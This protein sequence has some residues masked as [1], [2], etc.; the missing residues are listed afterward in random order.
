MFSFVG[1]AFHGSNHGHA[2][3]KNLGGEIEGKGS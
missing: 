2:V 1:L 3:Q